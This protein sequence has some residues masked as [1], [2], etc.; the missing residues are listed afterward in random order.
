[1]I[2]KGSFCVVMSRPVPPLATPSV[3]ASVIAPVVALLGVRPV[4]PA[5]NEVTPMP[6]RAAHEGAPPVLPTRTSPVAPTAV[7]AIAEV[8]EPYRTPFAVSVDAPVPPRATE[9]W[10]DHPR[11]RDVAASNALAGVP[12]SV[13]VTFV[14]SVL[15]SAAPPLMSVAG[16]VADAVSAD[17]PLPLTYPVSVVA[18]VPPFATIS[19]P[20]SVIR[21]RVARRWRK[22]R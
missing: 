11:V 2:S 22:A 18:P 3:P 9:S 7:A 4:V 17:V 21:T 19:V 1:M 10:P 5:L 15:V 6:V 8:P 20:A 14:S 16:I 13:R 12:P